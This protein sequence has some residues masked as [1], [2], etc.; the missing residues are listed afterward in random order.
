MPL[1]ALPKAFGFDNIVEKGFFPHLFNTPEH[2]GYVGVLPAAATF[3]PSTMHEKIRN[4]FLRW[5]AVEQQKFINV[6]WDF[7]ANMIKYCLSGVRIGS[8]VI[9]IFSNTINSIVAFWPLLECMTIASV[10]SFLFRSKYLPPKTI[11]LIPPKG[12]RHKSTQSKTTSM[13]LLLEEQK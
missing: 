3:S 11:C 5:Y 8:Y 1:S 9:K 12:Y 13:W 2:Q 6:G 7:D 4:E 10:T